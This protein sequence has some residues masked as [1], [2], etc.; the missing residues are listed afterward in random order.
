MQSL[1][2]ASP[3]QLFDPDLPTASA[4]LVSLSCVA[5][6]YAMNPSEDLALLGCSLAQTLNAP[7]YA[8]SGLITSAARQLLR[9]WQEL[10]QA[11][12]TFAMQQAVSE[13]VTPSATMQ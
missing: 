13:F 10:L 7:E 12:Q 8:E 2:G 3:S 6:R 9:E 11:H 4:V 5:T 1:Q